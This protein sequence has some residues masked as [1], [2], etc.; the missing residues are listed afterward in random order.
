MIILIIITI[1]VILLGRYAIAEGRRAEQ[2]KK[3]K[4]NLNTFETKQKNKPR[5][6]HN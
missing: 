2:R 6:W 1:V 3:L 4:K 5:G